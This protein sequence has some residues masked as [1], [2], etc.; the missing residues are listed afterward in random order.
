M[1]CYASHNKEDKKY[2][3]DII[4]SSIRGRPKQLG[5]SSGIIKKLSFPIKMENTF[6]YDSMLQKERWP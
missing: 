1:I 4:K 3:Q 5:L 6:P 2:M